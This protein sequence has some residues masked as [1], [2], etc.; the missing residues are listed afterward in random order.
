MVLF[1]FAIAP[2]HN[3]MSIQN[4]STYGYGADVALSSNV[5]WLYPF[6]PGEPPNVLRHEFAACVP[7]NITLAELCCSAVNGQF[8]QSSLANVRSLNEAQQIEILRER[9]P[10]QNLT[11]SSSTNTGDLANATGAGEEGAMHWCSMSYNPMSADPLEGIGFS[12]GGN[13]LGNVPET[14]NNWITCFNNNT[15]ADQRATN[16]V[17]YV[18]TALDLRTG[19]TI[20]GFNRTFAQ[21]D[22]NNGAGRTKVGRWSGVLSVAILAGLWS[23]AL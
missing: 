4:A 20:E 18:C 2:L 9:Y 23:I 10:D 11:V 19:G 13:M 5:T 12:S 16:K 1:P 22:I 21:Q 17:A 15:S 8:V 7:S 3:I 6:L 14:M